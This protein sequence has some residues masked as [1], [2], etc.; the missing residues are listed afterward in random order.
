MKIKVSMMVKDPSTSRYKEIEPT[1]GF[2]IEEESFFLDGPVTRRIAVLDFEPTGGGLHAGARFVPPAPGH[3]MGSYDIGGDPN[4][5][6][7]M[8]SAAFMQVNAYATVLRTLHL[9]EGPDTLGRK[10]KWASGAS[11]LLVVPRAGLAANASYQRASNSLQLFFF[12]LSPEA[13]DYCY[14][15]LSRDVIA[16]ETGHAVLDAIA[17]DLYTCITPQ[18]LA[19]HETIADL[20]ALLMAISSRALADKVLEDTGGSI[21][22]SNAFCMLAEEVGLALYPGRR[23]PLRSLLNTSK[24]EPG[25]PNEP[26]ALSEVL[27]GALYR[28]LVRMHTAR[29]QRYAAEERRTEFS[30]SGEALYKASQQFKRMVF[31]ALDYLPPGEVSFASFGRAIIAADQA[32][33]H[34]P[35]QE[36][37]RKWLCEEFVERNI[38]AGPEALRVETNIPYRPLKRIDLRQLVDSDWLAYEF[39]NRQ[40][41]YLGIPRHIP[42]EVLPRL[43]V[44]KKYYPASGQEETTH[45]CVFK[46]AWAGPPENGWVTKTG[47][48]LAIDWDTQ[49]ISALL[50]PQPADPQAQQD[51]ATLLSKL[52]CAAGLQLSW[53]QLGLGSDIATDVERSTR[54]LQAF[55]LLAAGEEV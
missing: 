51:R 21:D 11:Q 37:E 38:V 7:V 36:Q 49:Q 20:T 34:L 53:Q 14:T 32:L 39:A 33:H 5:P 19:L 6:A 12:R 15:S 48:T 52:D 46:V 41:D 55:S 40:R 25:A 35:G 9:L 43:E 16:H 44:R 2:E 8:F 45:E 50:R 18:S 29:R 54:R 30:V 17:P 1:E 4:D 10:I 27:S 42:F 22:N 3:V 28:L 26:H 31:R 13:S 47:T 24:L 23:G